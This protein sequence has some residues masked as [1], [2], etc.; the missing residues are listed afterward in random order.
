MAFEKINFALGFDEKRIP[1]PI[2]ILPHITK[3][4]PATIQVIADYHDDSANQFVSPVPNP[5]SIVLPTTIPNPSVNLSN[6]FSTT[7][8]LVN[9]MEKTIKYHV[10]YDMYYD[11]CDRND[12]D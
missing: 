2:V 9:G 12:S 11:V 3:E 1:I 4:H 7:I 5:P 10:V 8:K 6:Y